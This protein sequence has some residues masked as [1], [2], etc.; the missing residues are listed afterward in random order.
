MNIA[1]NRNVLAWGGD[2]TAQENQDKLAQLRVMV[3]GSGPLAQ[4]ILGSLAGLGVGYTS[5]DGA[6]IGMDNA[7][8]NSKDLDFLCPHNSFNIGK[9]KV[10][11]FETVINKIKS[12]C[13]Y[14]PEFSDFCV[15]HAYPHQPNIII[16]ATNDPISKEMALGYTLSHRIPFISASVN[17]DKG[18]A[19]CH[20]PKGDRNKGRIRNYRE[21]PDLGAL[22]LNE[23][24]KDKQ[25]GYTS[26]V[27]S[28]IV[29]EEIRKYL[30]KHNYN[31]TPIPEDTNLR[32]NHIFTYNP[33]SKTRTGRKNDIDPSLAHYYGGKKALIIG[34]G[35]LGNSLALNLAYLGFGK[36]DFLDMDNVE[37]H[38]L[39]R[40]LLLY[41]GVGS[42]K[43][44]ILSQ[45]V[46]EINQKISTNAIYGRVGAVTRNDHSWLEQLF[47]KEK[48]LW[49]RR[50]PQGRPDFPSSLNEFIN[51]RYSSKNGEQ[52]IDKSQLKNYDFILGGVDNK[53]ARLWMNQA[54]IHTMVP[55][56]DGGSS[57]KGGQ[58]VAY[59]P[60][61]TNCVDCE[62]KLMGFPTRYS[63]IDGPEGSVVMSNMIIG[64]MMVGE[65]IKMAYNKLDKRTGV[66]SIYNT[67]E[68]SRIFMGT[69]CERQ[70]RHC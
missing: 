55:Y 60:G 27:I 21:I 42:R 15:A 61:Y 8:I 31:S 49:E 62:V 14:I 54:A 63:C 3:V 65:L 47:E 45:R 37:V 38:N 2:E 43:A 7:R 4:Y 69:E 5:D 26:S 11:E 12:E 35:A 59:N 56:I 44:D 41:D 66:T 19:V 36:I 51:Q 57:P 6:I 32:S 10:K 53:F 48:T 17:K 46:K 28:G 34:C 13:N 25:E 39:S 40:Q 23:Y 29:L 1:D 50:S 52:L 68:K 70:I 30:F 20:W 16:D 67:F 22:I 18:S 58:V 24:S 33:Y 9:E 64:G